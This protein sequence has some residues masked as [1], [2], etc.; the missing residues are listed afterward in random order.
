MR[1]I[2]RTILFGK[3]RIK[4]IVTNGNFANGVI[5]WN[6]SSCS[7]VVAAG[8]CLVTATG[9]NATAILMNTFTV[10][11]MSGSKWYVRIKFRVT[12]A[13]CVLL[14]LYTHNGTTA[15]TAY[16]ASNPAQ[17]RWYEGSGVVTQTDAGNVHLRVSQQYA[18]AAT[19]MNKVM[20][21]DGNYGV[22]LVDISKLPAII[23]SKSDAEI[24]TLLD[25]WVWFEDYKLI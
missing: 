15:K 14:R 8:I 17:D 25:S 1:S 12:N 7:L 9:G 23:Q 6:K 13:A 5:G 16:S 20:E 19:A 18:D 24:K 3:Y 4:N 22:M 2:L 21:I 11:G 10:P